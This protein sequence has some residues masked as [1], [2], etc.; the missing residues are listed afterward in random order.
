M[1]ADIE[2]PAQSFVLLSG[3]PPELPQVY[4]LPPDVPESSEKIAVAYY[5]CNEHF[6]RTVESTFTEKG[7]LCVFRWSYSTKI[8]E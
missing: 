5:G 3:G 1:S 7:T 6:E 2:E 8:A 4:R